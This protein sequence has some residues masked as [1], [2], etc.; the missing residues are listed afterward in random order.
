MIE[1]TY[2]MSLL[3]KW[4]DK[5]VVKVITGV[6][7]CGK[8]TLMNMFCDKLLTEGVNDA[9]I[10]HLNLEDIDNEQFLDYKTLYS[11]IKGRQQ[12]G[13]MNYVFL[14]EIQMVGNF[15]KA[16]DSMQLLENIDIYVTGS[17]AYLLSGEIATLLSGRYVE[18]KMFPLSFR[19]YMSVQ[20]MNV[21]VESAYRRYIEFG[22][23]PYVTQLDSDR[24]LVQNYLSGL[25][26]T[27]VLKDVI[28]R[29][30]ISD[31]MMLESVV[32]FLADNIGNISVTKRISDTMVSAGRKISTHTV[33][34]YVSALLSS[35]IFYAAVRYDV[36]G[37]QYLKSGHKLYLCDVGLKNI[38]IG[39]KT[40]DLGHILENVIFMEL[41]RRGNEVYVGKVGDAEIDFI[42]INGN[43][44]T[45]YQVS[46]SVRD[47]ATLHRELAPLLNVADSY[48]KYLLT[49]DNDPVVMHNGIRQMYA[50]DWLLEN[51]T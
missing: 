14:D 4:K 44:K 13:K 25:Y 46:L 42:T 51:P 18:I 7:R 2:Y 31:V 26:N 34:N 37:R 32:R 45:Y 36:K 8:S 9:Q 6:R 30:R 15:H 47:S 49:L 10:T 24:T 40:G 29:S 12:K 5:Q 28:A 22:A 11:Y 27:I 50:L 19:E 1:R 41:Q 21:S 38:I 17:N 39:T 16:I 33:E 35:Y 48:P 20:P 3:T 23:F 43:M